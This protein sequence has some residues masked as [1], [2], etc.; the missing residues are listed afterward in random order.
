LEIQII[1]KLACFRFLEKKGAVVLTP[2][3]L[4]PIKPRRANAFA[5]FLEKKSILVVTE[6]H[7]N[8][9][10]LMPYFCSRK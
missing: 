2:V 9:A 10:E 3:A 8:L 4:D 6:F 7:L 5:S 1:N